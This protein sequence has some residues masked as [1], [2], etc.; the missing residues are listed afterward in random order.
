MVDDRAELAQSL[1][2][3]SS[4]EREPPGS[5]TGAAP[6]SCT[7]AE[8]GSPRGDPEGGF[9]VSGRVTATLYKLSGSEPIRV[10]LD[11]DASIGQL[12]AQLRRA[13]PGQ[14]FTQYVE[15]GSV[16][17]LGDYPQSWALSDSYTKF[18][19]TGSVR[20][21]LLSGT[22]LHFNLTLLSGTACRCEARSL[23]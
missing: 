11:P 18:M 19:L 12:V 5:A 14:E 9:G 13:L 7:P 17:L 16:V 20:R 23:P 10:T 1:R 22:A 21:T 3:T 4:N 2:G 8:P 6:V 15:R